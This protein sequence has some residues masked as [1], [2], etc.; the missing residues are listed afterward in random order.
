MSLGARSFFDAVIL[1]SRPAAL[2]AAALLSRRGFRVCVVRHDD[3]P[4]GYAHGG[5][6][7]KRGHDALQFTETNVFRRVLAE[8]AL[9]PT[10]RR[11]LAQAEPSLQLVL[12]GHR[13]D[14]GS[15]PGALRAELD[16]E[17]PSVRR[18]TEDFTAH[19]AR[20]TAALDAVLA[21][22]VPWP[23]EGFFDKRKVAGALRE[24]G[25]K[26]DGSGPDPLAGFPDAHPFRA[27]AQGPAR[28]ATEAAPDALAPLL[29]CR[30]HASATR[31]GGVSFFEGGRD[32]L[33]KLLEDKVLQHGGELRPRD[34][35]AHVLARRGGV[36]GV[37]L[38][39]TDEIIGCTYVLASLD[40]HEAAALTEGEP[41]DDALERRARHFEDRRYEE[42]ALNLVLARE[43]VPVGLGP[44]CFVVTD[45][46]RPLYG[47][48]L[49][50]VERG[51]PDAQGR[52][53]LT[54]T[55]LYPSDEPAPLGQRRARV[56]AA[57]AP[58]LPF[59]ERHLIAVDS[60]HDGL[61]FEPL[62]P[63]RLD[64]PPPT[65]PALAA[66]SPSTP[67]TRDGREPMRT[68]TLVPDGALLGAAATPM[69][70]G[71]KRMLLLGP[72]VL[73]GLGEE[74][75]LLAAVSAA[76]VVTA[77]DPSRERMRRELWSRVDT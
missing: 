35:V 45:A 8:L 62:R 57:L 23:P 36:E 13:V 25:Y 75:E 52:V 17:F 50:A 46:T 20:V 32:A 4:N 56:R 24:T 30:A 5:V 26:R 21:L 1:G 15:K 7:L 60:P 28:F 49:V 64:A 40:E 47:A 71:L 67:R 61:P 68:R 33:V 29:L 65:D 54:A 12:P 43:G 19:C 72:Q 76:R 2:V 38:D 48:N 41:D 22:D 10:V 73:P 34:R 39:T 6:V 31:P 44:R 58:V 53:V 27:V 11:K 3:R 74:G 69:Q 66:P 55:A 77:S 14:G 70:P 37:Q 9:G 63:E 59:L 18:A 42:F 51:A 16:R